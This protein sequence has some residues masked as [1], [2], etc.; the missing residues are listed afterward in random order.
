MKFA[1]ISL[2]LALLA[3]SA[4]AQIGGQGGMRQP[5][6]APSTTVKPSTGFNMPGANG[7]GIMKTTEKPSG[8]PGANGGGIQQCRSNGQTCSSSS[9]CCSS[10]QCTEGM[11]STGGGGGGMTP[12]GG[13]PSNSTGGGYGATGPG[14]KGGRFICNEENICVA[15]SESIHI[16]QASFAFAYAKC[17]E[18]CVPGRPHPHGQCKKDGA[19]CQNNRDCCSR[20]CQNRLGG[21]GKMCGPAQSQC[22][23]DGKDCRSDGDCC[24]GQ[25]KNRLGGSGKMCGPAPSPGPTPSCSPLQPLA[26]CQAGVYNAC[27]SETLFCSVKNTPQYPNDESDNRHRCQPITCAQDKDCPQG[28]TCQ[29]GEWRGPGTGSYTACA[30]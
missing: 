18:V 16:G 5:G 7:G 23:S 15:F 2:C 26:E 27:C 22:K 29:F 9:D 8:M 1:S 25:C 11:C 6:T 17:T 19:N 10:M 28:L 30:K 13:D 24:S 12:P 21:S 4:Q 14:G 3:A 20:T